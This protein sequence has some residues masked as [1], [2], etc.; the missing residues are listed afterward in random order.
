MLFAL[1][2]LQIGVGIPGRDGRRP[3]GSVYQFGNPA[4]CQRAVP[5]K[6]TYTA[7]LCSTLGSAAVAIPYIDVGVGA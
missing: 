4:M 5:D 7:F 6:E 1:A 3:D 2:S